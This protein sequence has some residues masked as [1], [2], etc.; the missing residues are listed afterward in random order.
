M[1]KVGNK[2]W[3]LVFVVVGVIF[4]LNALGITDINVFFDGWWTLFIIIPS[5]IEIIKEPTR[6]G[7]YIWLG[8][9]VI[10]LLSAQGILDMSKIWKLIFPAILV[11]I[12]LGIIFKDVVGSKVNEKIK[13]L[14][15]DD[16]EEYYATFSGQ[17]LNFSGEDFKGASLNAIFGGI[18]LDLRDVNI[19]QD[20]V[21]NATSVFGG[22]DILVPNN[23]NV[24]VKS[25]SLFGGVDNKVKTYN[26]N[27]PTIYI[28]GF[29]LFGGVE[30]K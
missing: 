20:Q 4:G 11:A 3:G 9:G 8:I 26:E 17:K 15:K 5:I 24:K 21:V 27:L 19:T 6:I 30:I 14:N 29:C 2:I 22:I 10:F 23:V 18:D 7:N 12:G 28:K 16:K 25:N 1:K 13:E